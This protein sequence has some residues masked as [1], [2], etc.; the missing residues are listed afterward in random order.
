VTT[1]EDF[2]RVSVA[3]EQKM[4]VDV[5]ND[6]KTKDESKTEEIVVEP[7]DSD[8]K[9]KERPTT[10]DIDAL[11]P[12]FWTLQHSFSEPPRLFDESIFKEFQQGLEATL[13]KFKE[14]PTVIQAG[15]SERKRETKSR[16]DEDYDD[17][18]S[19]FNPKYLTSRDLFKLEVHDGRVAAQ[20]VTVTDSMQLSDLAF[21]RHI[22][23]QALILIDFLLTL[24]EKAKKK[25]YYQNAQKA[26]QYSFTLR[27]EDVSPCHPSPPPQLAFC[28]Y[29][30]DHPFG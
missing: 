30:R 7:A 12:V 28:L 29:H 19:S 4:D 20:Y 13:A 5:A 11:Y 6:E 3:E 25:P 21:Q 22:L 8:S 18:A 1:F 15:D 2:L 23:V 24:T 27:E 16:S 17:F 26:M 10:M 9:A 14:V